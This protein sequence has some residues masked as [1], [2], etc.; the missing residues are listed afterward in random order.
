MTAETS[1]PPERV[2]TRVAVA[3]VR[4]LLRL[5]MGVK[6][7]MAGPVIVRDGRELDLDAQLIMRVTGLF[8][9]RSTDPAVGPAWR[10]AQALRMSAIGAGY[11][12]VVGVTETTVAGAAGPLKARVYDPD[13]AGTVLV[14]FHGGGWVIGDLDTHDGFCR[15]LARRGG[16]RIV[17]VD[18]RLAPE[19]P[20]PA[21]IDDA[22]SAFRDIVGRASEFGVAP[23]RVAVGGDSAGGYLA[24][25]LCQR[26]LA[27][28][29]PNP[30]LQLLIYP[31]TE[32]T[33]KSESR[34]T[35]AEGFALTRH[36]IDFYDN[37]FLVP[38]IDRARPDVS[39]F[40]AESTA[41]L[42]PAV[43]ITAGFDPLR[44][45]GEAYAERLRVDGVP[46]VLRRFDGYMH[47]FVNNALA[48]GAA[49]EEIAGLLADAVPAESRDTAAE[50]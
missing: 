3:A 33:G 9:R 36:D 48:F 40:Y 28:G 43:V 39:P 19:H 26:V 5:P 16:I 21:A 20:Y 24:A 2:G 13:H 47:A 15:T 44:D 50:S 30:L 6:R 25:M 12:A 27:D 38:E 42:P 8:S 17:A 10:R 22:E 31:P 23:E 34:A 45:E 37:C 46:V 1:L 11:R 18:Y 4:G 41:G 7:A 35:F 32:L 29:G 14:Y 49:V